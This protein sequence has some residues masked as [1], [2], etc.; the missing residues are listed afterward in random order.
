MQINP[1]P[2][3]KHDAATGRLQ[4]KATGLSLVVYWGRRMGVGTWMVDRS[5]Q[6]LCSQPPAPL[7]C[8]CL[9]PG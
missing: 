7:A 3:K 4:E 5:A 6:Q 2:A 8:L 1:G 9:I